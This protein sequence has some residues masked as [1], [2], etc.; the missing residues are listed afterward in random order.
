MAKVLANINALQEATDDQND[1]FGDLD[2]TAQKLGNTLKKNNAVFASN[3]GAM[4]QVTGNS[5][6][7]SRA[8]QQNTRDF[9]LLQRMSLKLRAAF[10]FLFFV[11]VG[12]I[13]EFVI[14]A[15]TLASVTA[16]F[17]LGNLAIK[18]Y[19]VTLGLIG[20][21]LASVSA[22]AAVALSTFKEYNAALTA[23][24]YNQRS[25]YG[26]SIQ[27]SA[28]AM[29]GMTVDTNLATMGVVQLTQAYNVMARSARVTASQQKALSGS[30]DFLSGTEDVNK[31]FQAMAN[32]VGLLS[33]NKRVTSEVT[34]AA[35]GVSKEFAKEIAKQK[36]KSAGAILSKMA[37]GQL[38]FD[39]GVEGRFKTVTQTLVAQFKRYITFLARDISDFGDLL[40]NN[41]KTILYGYY[42]NI[43]DYFARTRYE[44]Y[45]FASGDLSNSLVTFG[46]WMENFSVKLI[47]DYLPKID[48]GVAW[49]R[50]TFSDVRKSFDSFVDSLQKFRA[51]SR[52]IV[53][54][55]GE[56]LLAIFRIFGRNAE[57]LAYLAE[58]NE[59]SYLRWGKSLE[60]LIF[61]IGDFFAALKVA[62]TEALPVLT[63]VVN[64]ISTLINGLSRVISLVGTLNLFGSGGGG[65]SGTIGAGMGPG[66]GGLV[67]LGMMM[68]LYKGRR[69]AYRDDFY[70]TGQMSPGNASKYARSGG[71]SYGIGGTYGM[72]RRILDM[73]GGLNPFGGFGTYAMAATSGARTG[74]VS[75]YQGARAGGGGFIGAM[76]M[77]FR[78]AFKSR[79][80]GSIANVGP[81]TSGAFAASEAMRIYAEMTGRDADTRAFNA[82]AFAMNPYTGKR[83]RDGRNFLYRQ[84][85]TGA[86][87][88]YTQNTI[89][90]VFAAEANNIMASG[91]SPT[92]QKQAL[93]DL[94]IRYQD[95]Y[96]A[97]NQSVYGVGSNAR[98]M[99]VNLGVRRSTRLANL[100]TII[101]GTYAADTA[102]FRLKTA[103]DDFAKSDTRGIYK[104]EDQRMKAFLGHVRGQRMKGRMAGFGEAAQAGI[105][106]MYS[107]ML[108]IMGG[109]ALSTGVTGRI[110][111][112]DTR[113]AVENALG[114]GSIFGTAGMGTAA[115][116]SLLGSTSTAKASFGGALA[117]YSATKPV[118]DILEGAFGPKGAVVGYVIQGVAAVVGGV[119]GAI[120][121]GEN[122]V[123]QAKEAA[124]EVTNRRLQSMNLALLGYTKSQRYNAATG[125]MENVFTKTG[126]ASMDAMR[127]D[128]MR[129][130]RTLSP[131]FGPTGYGQMQ[132]TADARRIEKELIK[133]G[134]LPSTGLNI[135]KNTRNDL[136]AYR[137]GFAEIAKDMGGTFRV[138]GTRMVSDGAGGFI[139]AVFS[140]ERSLASAPGFQKIMENPSLMFKRGAKGEITGMKD[141][142]EV[143]TAAEL[144]VQGI[145]AA[146]AGTTG[147]YT[148]Y[149]KGS[150]KLEMGEIA[151][152]GVMARAEYNIQQMM[153]LFGMTEEAVIELARQKNVNIFD[154]FA[155]LT[156][157]IRDM[158]K[159]TTR[160][161]AQMRQAINDVQVQALGLA[162]AR[163][164]LRNT[165]A[166][167]TESSNALL[168]SGGAASEEQFYDVARTAQAYYALTD[169]DNPFAY[170]EFLQG[171]AGGNLGGK[172]MTA[173]Q[174]A[175]FGSTG[176]M[177]VVGGI[178]TKTA[179]GYSKLATQEFMGNA[180]NMGYA[181]SDTNADVGFQAALNKIFMSESYG[182]DSKNAL[183]NVLQTQ[184]INPS[185]GQIDFAKIA[186]TGGAGAAF[187]QALGAQS[188]Y[189]MESTDQ[190][191]VTIGG[192]TDASVFNE[193]AK[194]MGQAFISGIDKPEFW[195]EAPEWWTSMLGT[196]FVVEG[197]TG[198][199]VPPT[200]GTNRNTG[201]P[202]TR[203]PR[204][205][206][207]G[208]TS[209][210]RALGGTM[211]AHNYFNSMLTGKR[212]VT[213][214][215]RFDNLGSPSSDHAAGRAF[216][217]TGQNLGQYQ[218]LINGAGG[219]AEFHGVAGSRHLHVVPP[220]GDTR[221]PRVG[222]S[223]GAG[224][225]QSVT[226]NVYGAP[227]Q[228]EKAIAKQVVAAIEERERRMRERS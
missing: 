174:L 60:R 157:V 25:V 113:R 72:G 6:K 142:S 116:L 121:A 98:S 134:A 173:E 128:Q 68:A 40:L 52:I 124:K 110:G 183:L 223:S 16:A 31:A 195:E 164:N 65:K 198:S 211:R 88:P 161:A 66:V 205:G 17:K 189:A 76:G 78:G 160:T 108:G 218:Q 10:R 91:L 51:G 117:G 101:G 176:A 41:A 158:G 28:A 90:Q 206:R 7:M 126:P 93:R 23:F 44:L 70:K 140:E 167:F 162:D 225:T 81:T 165:G 168:N 22:A 120:K 84:G 222:E 212:Y 56:P 115:G 207:I 4:Q 209:T 154:P 213:S 73:G 172:Q 49:L 135:D 67:S 214:S 32:F 199:F 178:A 103:Y 122:R 1:S 109:L 26:D 217:L 19:N 50:K 112:Q 2:D 149:V 45:S 69:Y 177:S 11:V 48:G 202:D 61:S 166:A 71:G 94:D 132:T 89:D 35:Q 151:R 77:G 139:P 170:L 37:S 226:V 14:T 169:P 53:D 141:L 197:G 203:S 159:T 192:L 100:R 95:A 150:A 186:A 8:L 75:G 104:T 64:A 42:K 179:G 24:Q 143:L 118:K 86:A 130:L 62:F 46:N 99:R 221:T 181:F 127:R 80:S 5:G 43:R 145:G 175:R 79:G 200:G 136:N 13:A 87:G 97:M 129:G 92:E 20:A 193:A 107:P 114:I 228:S 185:T 102:E 190:L 9:T 224:M 219:F 191:K 204:R 58:D 57:Q 123:K 106:R 171:F 194:Q 227:G 83:F 208:D 210:S 47:R 59:E 21:A 34:T 29:R 85:A 105:G 111:D 137:A 201:T 18:A 147:A 82:A 96:T 153:R 180:I 148:G 33:K 74:F 131:L 146:P 152:A 216:D 30:M 155:E 3:S 196:K 215:L 15:T 54:M 125:Q 163:L 138:G 12:L 182:T 27:A 39:A 36:D 38:A 133:T 187:V 184:L 156:D 188:K 220:M 144:G 119:Y 63:S 55:F